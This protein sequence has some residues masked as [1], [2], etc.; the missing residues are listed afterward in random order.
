MNYLDFESVRLKLLELLNDIEKYLTEE[1]FKERILAARNRLSHE[2]MNVLIVG[3]FSRGKSTFIN[4]L[5]RAPVLP[6]KVNPTTATINLIEFDNDKKIEIFYSDGKKEEINLPDEKIN[7]FL[8]NYVTTEN[9]NASKIT[10]IKIKFPG[11]PQL[12]NC[13]I[14]DTPGVNDLDEAREDITYKYLSQ[15]DACIVILDS[16]QPLSESERRFLK[17][18]VLSKDIQRLLFVINRLDEIP[19]PNSQPD[20]N[21]SDRLIAYVKKLIIENVPSLENPEVY[22]VASKAALKARFT[23]EENNN[24]DEVFNNFENKLIEFV[25]LNAT[26]RRFPDHINSFFLIVQDGISSIHQRIE[27]IKMSGADLEIELKKLHDKQIWLQA[28]LQ[29]LS[30]IIEREKLILTRNLSQTISEKLSNLKNNLLSIARNCSNDGDLIILKS[31]LSTGI[32]DVVENISDIA[33]D[34]NENISLKLKEH[35]YDSLQS[36]STNTNLVSLSNMIKKS[37]NLSGV[38]LDTFSSKNIEINKWQTVGT[39]FVLAGA[40]GHVGSILLGPIG[41]AAA[42]IGSVAISN[43]MEDKRRVAAWEQIR[44]QTIANVSNQLNQIIDNIEKASKDI[45]EKECRDIEKIFRDQSLSKIN[46]ISS[47]INE[48]KRFLSDKSLDI[49]T[50]KNNLEKDR[51]FLGLILNELNKLQE[52]LPL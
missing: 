2:K 36:D 13:L 5:L 20:Q 10:Q 31:K 12:S 50:Q 43:K 33:L 24:W 51:D 25:S 44:S 16:Q 8:D 1:Q 45:A 22:A 9:K 17:D 37:T 28:K 4:A 19:R 38:T 18:K 3:E 42:I 14:V 52:K 48:Q 29:A 32:R 35:F 49:E 7:K 23:K 40:L 39:S 47:V 41:I 46:I 34:F 6:S 30:A 15:A 21:I 27:L 26:K 11:N